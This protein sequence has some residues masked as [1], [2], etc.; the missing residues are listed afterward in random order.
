MISAVYRAQVE[1]L[2]QVLPHVATEACFAL[3][4]GT[5][6]NLFVRDLP[7]LSVDIDLTYLPFH[8]RQQALEEITES[9]GR[10]K[11]RIESTLPAVRVTPVQQ[12]D[13]QHA[14]LSCQSPSAQI[15]IEVN[16]TLRGAIVPSR[17]MQVSEKVQE[18][19]GKFAAISV[20]SHA[21]LFGGKICA[22]LD[23]QHP[24]D[25]FDIYYLLENEG[26]SDEL[27]LGFITCL[28]S[29]PRPIN[30]ILSPRHQDQEAAYHA[31]FAGMTM[32]PFSYEDY[33][34]T[35]ERLFQE[36]SAWLSE[37]ERQFLI[38]FKQG[39]PDWELV[40]VPALKDL[41]AVQ[42]KLKNI[43]RLITQAPAKH[44]QQLERLE[45]ILLRQD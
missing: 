8:N 36:V 22:A 23:R 11:N 39:N 32:V 41:P 1:L 25:L 28:I 44:A 43:Q 34:S 17:L 10:I 2:L 21:E 27:R 19:F 3:K 26:L 6:I 4:G 29:S 42:W 15:K 24:R 31:Q 18:E 33:L 38:S 9:L 37:V 16:T 20:V 12:S 5:A 35:R 30:E 13:G 40:P 14:K 45:A 7:R